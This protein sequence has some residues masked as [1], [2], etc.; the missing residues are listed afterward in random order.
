MLGI[1]IP[2][3]RKLVY[4]FLSIIVCLVTNFGLRFHHI[5]KIESS[6]MNV[7]KILANTGITLEVMKPKF[8]GMFF[9]NI[10]TQLEN[11][12]IYAT[13]S[14]C[15][16]YF[17][18]PEID[19]KS[20]FQNINNVQT[21]VIL[22]KELNGYLDMN[23]EVAKQLE[24]Q[25]KYKILFFTQNNMNV[26][27]D[28]HNPLQNS[29]QNLHALLQNV[30]LKI[31]NDHHAHE[32]FNLEKVN[33][34]LKNANTNQNNLQ[35]EVDNLNIVSGVEKFV[36]YLP[37][38]ISADAASKNIFMNLTLTH[39]IIE[40]MYSGNFNTHTKAFDFS[41]SGSTKRVNIGKQKNQ[42]DLV[43]VISKFP[44]FIDY[45]K[46][47]VLSVK[48]HEN[49][50]EIESMVNLFAKSVLSCAKNDNDTVTFNVKDTESGPMF[51]GKPMEQVFEELLHRLRNEV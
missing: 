31:Q 11:T 24:M 27:I 15:V 48:K 17:N 34:T 7:K 21:I 44:I 6:I 16:L 50:K 37:K 14:D 32:L 41:V 42:S 8:H 22:P 36:Q 47:L 29:I 18:V 3:M 30:V 12:E 23:A 25:K 33:V 46:G 40:K 10:I 45:F 39:D 19:V 9:W 26:Y 35:I 49:E 13:V 1:K 43:F 5:H 28:T 38:S 2:Y 51:Q 20:T 4:I